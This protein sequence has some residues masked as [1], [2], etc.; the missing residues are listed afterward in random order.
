MRYL[1]TGRRILIGVLGLALLPAVAVGLI[2]AQ[3]PEP[4][5]GVMQP[6]E[7]A[8]MMADVGGVIPIQGRLTDADG[9]PV[10][11]GAY[12]LT[13]RLYKAPEGGTVLCEDVDGPPDDPVNPVEVTNG[14]FTAGMD[15]CTAEDIDGKQLYLEIEVGSDGPMEPRRAIYPVP[16]AWS[17]RPG[18]SVNGD[19]AGGNVLWVRNGSTTDGTT[20]VFAQAGGASGE[21]YG[22]YGASLSPD[23]YGGRFFGGTGLYAESFTGAAIEAGGNG[24]IQS[25]ARS[26]LWISGNSLQKGNSDDT[27]RW[28]YDDYGGYRVY[29]GAEGGGPHVRRVVLPVTIPGQVYGQNVTV[30]GMDLY[31]AI[32][33][34]S[35]AIEAILV[36]RQDGVGAGDTILYDINLTC[37]AGLQCSK[38]WNLTENNVLSAQRG[39]LYIVLRLSFPGSIEYVQIGGV[40]LTME[41][42]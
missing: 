2:Q 5:E 3:G 7:V 33:G 37:G 11:D 15:W 6:Q 23:G 34:D 19:V 30:T 35:T 20:A 41:H 13:F 21:T 4:P 22:V 31:Y 10:P 18:A 40:R 17:L 1:M 25:T 12:T 14:L 36:R 28:E 27:T 9:N 16:Y 38:H 8:G 42:D 32:E 26:Y 24:I 29:S 39:I